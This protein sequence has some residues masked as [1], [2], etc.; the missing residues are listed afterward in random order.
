MPNPNQNT[1][2]NQSFIPGA[3]EEATQDDLKAVHQEIDEK[4]RLDPNVKIK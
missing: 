1:N 3:I 4:K 2:P